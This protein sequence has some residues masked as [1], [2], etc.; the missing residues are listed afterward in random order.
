MRMEMRE[1]KIL[2]KVNGKT[3]L[4]KVLENKPTLV[5]EHTMAIGKME[6]GT[7]KVLWYMI[8]RI[9]ILDNGRMERKT[10]K[11]LI[12]SNKQEWNTL[13]PGKQAKWWRVNGSI[14]MELAL[15]AISTIINQKVMESGISKTEIV[16]VASIHKSKGLMLTPKMLSSLAGRPLAISLPKYDFVGGLALPLSRWLY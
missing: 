14:P 11:E 2:I 5:L 3:I 12:F 7:E 1:Q 6:R 16:S 8:P 9:S 13:E 4:N 10:V 15:R